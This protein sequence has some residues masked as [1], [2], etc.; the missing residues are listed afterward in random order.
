MIDNI[1]MLIVYGKHSN[2]K[3]LKIIIISI[4]KVM[5]FSLQTSLK[6]SRSTGFQNYGLDPLHY[7]TAPELAWDSALKMS[8]VELE[9]ITDIYM[10]NFIENS[11]RGGISMISNRYGK[12]NCPYNWYFESEPDKPNTYLLYLDANNLNGWAMTQSLPTGGFKFL[13]DDEKR[14]M[15]PEDDIVTRLSSLPDDDGI[16]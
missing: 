15:F 7:Y 11:I 12:S 8:K 9:L 2:V 16:G 1:N 5:S 13:S 10:Y 14:L 6:K 4:S 3:P